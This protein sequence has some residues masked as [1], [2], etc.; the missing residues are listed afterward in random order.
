MISESYRS[1]G[2][3]IRRRRTRRVVVVVY[4]ALLVGCLVVLQWAD[5]T[6][7]S[8]NGFMHL[9]FPLQLL[10]FLPALLGGV[11]NGGMVKPFRGVH[12]VPLQERDDTQ[13]L[14]GKADAQFVGNDPDERETCER[15]RIHFLAYT[16]A[17]WMVLILLVVLLAV[18]CLLGADSTVWTT[19]LGAGFF[20][21]VALTLWSLP[22]SLILWTEPDMEEGR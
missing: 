18:Y 2:F 16:A 22:Q 3:S 8:H 12:F 14:F 17:R 21:L 7:P 9:L 15:D 5:T 4:W 11:R 20:Y 19:R 1:L 6:K 13:T 10:I